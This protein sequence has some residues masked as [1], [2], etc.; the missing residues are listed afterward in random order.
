MEANQI[1]VTDEALRRAASE[2]M[3][4]FLRV[5]TDAYLQAMGGTLTAE[6]MP[7]LNAS[8]HTLLAYTILRDELMEGGRVP[9]AIG[10]WTSSPRFSMPHAKC[11]TPIVRIWSVNAR[12]RSSW[13]CM[14]NTRFSTIWKTGFWSTRRSGQP[15]SHSMWTGIWSSLQRLK[16]ENMLNRKPACSIPPRVAFPKRNNYLILQTD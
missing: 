1:K 6:A 7:L 16:I 15:K 10:A 2:G 5:F 12:T 3:D 8:Q 9:Y 11:M 13:R 14:S 4:T